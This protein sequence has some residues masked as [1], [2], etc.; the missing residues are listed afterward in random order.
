MSCLAH[1]AQL[2]RMKEALDARNATAALIGGGTVLSARLA[3]RWLKLPWPVLHDPDRAVYRA[4]GFERML[5]VYQQSG[6]VVV[7]AAGMRLFQE[8]GANPRKAL[9]RAAILE[10]LDR[11]A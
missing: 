7:D 1:A 8:R 10:A 9:P 6:T 5:G 11:D 4:Y 3:T 2:G